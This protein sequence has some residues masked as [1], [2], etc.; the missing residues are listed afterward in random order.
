MPRAFRISPI[1]IPLLAALAIVPGRADARDSVDTR[2]LWSPAYSEGKS[3][4]F[5][6]T[7]SGWPPRTGR[8]PGE[9]PRTQAPSRTL[10]SR[11]TDADRLHGKLRWK[12]RCLCDSRRRRRADASIVASGRRHRPWLHTRRQGLFSSQREVFSRRHSQF[13]VVDPKVVSRSGCRCRPATRGRFH[14]M[15]SSLLTRR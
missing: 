5:T 9:S 2:L 1:I 15:G 11:R 6:P 13:F 7:I 8:A 10:I 14:R 4:S 12:R 3:P